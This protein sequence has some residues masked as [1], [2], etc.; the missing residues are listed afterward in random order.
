MSAQQ[1]ADITGV[2]LVTANSY[3]E[4][5]GG[6]LDTAMAL[7]FDGLYNVLELFSP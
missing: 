6:N 5:A 3:L 2:D 4:M 7:F 1:F